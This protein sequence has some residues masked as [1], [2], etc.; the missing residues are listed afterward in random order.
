MKTIS[1][2]V[3]MFN[4]ESNLREFHKRVTTVMESLNYNY[5]ICFVD[6][7]SSDNS[8]TILQELSLEDSHVQGF[9]LSRNYGHQIALTCGLDNVTG[10]AV[11]TMDG[12]LQHPP[13][14][15]PELI[16]KW[17]AG[18]DI[19]KTIRT[20]T[21]NIS[22][23]KKI[24][25]STY[26]KLLN[27]ISTV[28]ITPGGSDFRLMSRQV[29]DAFKLYRERA[30]FIRGMVNTLGFKVATVE[31][32]ADERFSGVSKFSLNKMLHFALDGIT[33]FSNLPLRWAFYIGI[34]MGLFSFAGL[35]HVFYVT[36]VF[37][38]VV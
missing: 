3:P 17:E 13:E 5:E 34:L 37:D 12:D 27:M 11:I 35:I 32:K 31:F 22:F 15:I 33:A 23:F 26:Y 28:E 21:D 6:D 14:I 24:T 16:S 38:A 8:T 25:S 9:I 30:R 19:V 18:F 1:I 10:D 7:G 20:S 36:Y 4:E 29:V 2:V